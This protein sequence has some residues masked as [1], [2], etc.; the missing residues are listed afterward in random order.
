MP[1]YVDI[2]E[3]IMSVFAF[4]GIAYCQRLGGHVRMEI[5]LK[6]FKGRLFWIAELF[7][8]VV[9]MIIIVILY[10]LFLASLKIWAI[11]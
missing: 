11:W 8:G 5:I 2:I 9:A 7:G 6:M 1:S 3:I 4:M 10:L